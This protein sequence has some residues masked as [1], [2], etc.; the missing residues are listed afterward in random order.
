MSRKSLVLAS[1]LAAAGFGVS[2]Q[3]ATP[4]P[5]V[6]QGTLTRAE[7]KADLAQARAEGFA[8]RGGEATI[9]ADSQVVGTRDRAE[10]RAEAA[11]LLADPSAKQRYYIGG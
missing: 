2:A 10:V 4:L 3:E 7:V 1:V 11:R 9:F 5:D 8:V 6:A